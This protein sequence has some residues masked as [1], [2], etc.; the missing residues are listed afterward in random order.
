MA[1]ARE[2]AGP[3]R[4]RVGRARA[5]QLAGGDWAHGGERGETGMEGMKGGGPRQLATAHMLGA[6]AGAGRVGEARQLAGCQLVS[7]QRVMGFGRLRR[8]R[9]LPVRR[10]ATA[11]RLGGLWAR[12]SI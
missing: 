3:S 12:A 9:D 4:L 1:W 7:R 6:W 5:C 2:G 10:E 11:G 8:G